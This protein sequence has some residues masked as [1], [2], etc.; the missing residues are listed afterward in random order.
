MDL[1]SNQCCESVMF[2]PYPRSE[3]FPSRI[4]Q[5]KYFLINKLFLSF[6]KHDPEDSSRIRILIFYS[7]RTRGQNAPDPGSATLLCQN[8]RRKEGLAHKVSLKNCSLPGSVCSAG[9]RGGRNI[10]SC[11]PGTNSLMESHWSFLHTNP[12]EK[13]AKYNMR[14]KR[15]IVVILFQ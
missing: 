15:Q 14:T 8:L 12:E 4:R 2:I 6:P 3:F 7:S 9:Q 11:S 10:S 1:R 13:R 5:F